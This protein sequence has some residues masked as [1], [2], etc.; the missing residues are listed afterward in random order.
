MTCKHCGVDIVLVDKTYVHTKNGY[1]AKIRCD[2]DKSGK[3]YGL[4]AEPK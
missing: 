1:M 2:P 3:P 4:E